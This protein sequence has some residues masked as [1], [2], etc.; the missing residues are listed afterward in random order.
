MLVINL[1]GAAGTGKSTTAAGLFHLIRHY[2]NTNCELVTEFAT[3]LCFEQAKPMLQD[4]IY[5][6][7]NQYHRLWRLRQ[8]GVEV[9]IT[10]SPLGIALIYAQRIGCRYRKELTALVKKFWEED[11]QVNI[12]LSIPAYRRKIYKG[13]DRWSKPSDWFEEGLNTLPVLY[14]LHQ[15]FGPMA[16]ENIFGHLLAQRLL[17]RDHGSTKL[18]DTVGEWRGQP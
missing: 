14:H 18:F 13:V 10:D 17:G 16:A 3:D 5:L 4:Q 9:A 12:R 2:T 8:L 6:V 15:G 11:R 1:Y 7:G